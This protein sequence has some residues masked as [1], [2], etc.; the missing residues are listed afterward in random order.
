MKSPAF[1]KVGSPTRRLLLVVGLCC[2]IFSGSAHA[3]DAMVI[4]SPLPDER[5]IANETLTL[6]VSLGGRRAEPSQVTWTSNL[7]GELGYGP[8]IQVSKLP[9]G[10]HTITVSFAGETQDVSVRVF[11]DLLSL[12]QAPPAASE[13]KRI[14]KDFSLSWMD[15]SASDEKWAAYDP[16]VFNQASLA[17]SKIVVFTNQDVLRHQAFSEPLPFSEGRSLYD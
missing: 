1:S 2:S 8:E 6:K 4:A 15:G 17:P 10:R 16:P 9:P 13:I 5:F 11:P 12:Y 3:R 7:S 14:Q